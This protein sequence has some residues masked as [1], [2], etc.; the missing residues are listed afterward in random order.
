MQSTDT[1]RRE[2]KN[3]KGKKGD[4]HGRLTL[5]GKTFMSVAYYKP[6]RIVEAECVCGVTRDYIYE[7]LVKGDTKSCG[8]LKS[9]KSR[10]RMTTHNLSSH[11]LY[12][13]YNAML[14][15]CYKPNDSSYKNY[16]GRGI[17]VDESWQENFINF[18]NWSIN[19][20]WAEGLQLDR[21]V[22]DGNYSPLNCRYVSR[23]VNNRNRR[24]NIMIT[25][26][27][28]TKCLWDWGIDS[29]C[30]IGKWGLRNR[31]DR[32]KWT[33]MELMISSPK[34]D[35]NKVAQNKKS[36]TY[37]TAFGEKKCM[38]AWLEDSRCL[39]KI[40]SLRD[41]LA[42][43]WDAEKAMNKPPTRNGINTKFIL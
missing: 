3:F 16:G 36:N 12:D 1:P 39:V 40:D 30:A 21:R 14:S 18:Y 9:E 24:N 25:A 7:L 13:V 27:G 10:E 2:Y 35:I 34:E 6:K 11:P 43:G 17:E 19:N 8:C 28:E 33:D 31:Y 32:G 42:K 23:D 22:N 5:T 4:I 38:S 29:R 41:R 20:G 26:F 37:L 15:R